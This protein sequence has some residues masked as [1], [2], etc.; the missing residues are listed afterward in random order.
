MIRARGH[1]GTYVFDVPARTIQ[2]TYTTVVPGVTIKN[3]TSTRHSHTN[4]SRG[5]LR[6]AESVEGTANYA[7]LQRRDDTLA[8]GTHEPY[9]RPARYA[10]PMLLLAR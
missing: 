8:L 2:P 5:L 10:P 1:S 7:S 4:Y 6:V 3:Y 9:T